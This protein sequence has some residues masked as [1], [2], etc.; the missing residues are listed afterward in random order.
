VDTAFSEDQMKVGR[1]LANKLLNV[2]K[3]VLA[4]GEAPVAADPGAVITD[5]VDRAMLA[6]VAATVAE[7]TEAFESFDYARALE[8]TEATFWW[9]CDD[10]VELVKSRAYLSQGAERAASTLAAL[11]AAL[12]TFHRLF[13]PFLPF[14][15]AEV[16]DWW[17]TGSV[18]RAAWPS[19]AEFGTALHGADASLLDAVG[20]VLARVRRSKTEA[21]VSQR[22]A[23]ELLVVRGP[24]ALLA[25]VR[26]GLA[27]LRDAGSVAAERFET[28]E[29]LTCEVTLTPPEAQ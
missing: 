1:K 13:A 19:T 6:R 21:K 7:A 4:A 26:L 20:D 5:A 15:T 23:V 8:R 24:E 27:D 12:S 25:Q 3:F 17:Q 22:A 28:G 16:W 14:T 10:Y 2:T 29:E 9:F 18:H 11:G